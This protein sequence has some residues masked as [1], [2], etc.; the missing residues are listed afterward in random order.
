MR[1]PLTEGQQK[2]YSFLVGYIR[3]NRFPPTIREIQ[4]YFEY[5][6]PN[7]VVAQLKQL[8]KKGYITKSSSKDGM[9]ARTMKLVDDVVGNYTIEASQLREAIKDLS[10]RGYSIK[11]NEAVELLNVLGVGIV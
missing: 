6:S 5:R 2:I 7:S 8:E 4:R 9:R 3:E 11:V 10:N 1:A